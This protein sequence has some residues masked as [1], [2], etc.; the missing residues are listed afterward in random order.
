MEGQHRRPSQQQ[1]QQ[2]Y[3][4]TTDGV[5]A[6]AR[7]TS[8]YVSALRTGGGSTVGSA[9]G[10]MVSANSGSAMAP[11]SSTSL[12]RNP[13]TGS[14]TAGSG[15]KGRPAPIMTSHSAMAAGGSGGPLSPRTPTSPAPALSPYFAS[16][17]YPGSLVRTGSNGSSLVGGKRTATAA[18]AAAIPAAPAPQRSTST[19]GSLPRPLAASASAAVTAAVPTSGPRMAYP[20]PPTSPMA[21]SPT[22]PAPVYDV[23]ALS[24]G[25]GVGGSTLGR[26]PYMPDRG[27]AWAAPNN[28]KSAPL[29]P[30]FSP[31]PFSPTGGS[32]GEKFGPLAPY[33]QEQ[34]QQQYQEQQ[35]QQ[36]QQQ[37]QQQGA[38][39]WAPQQQAHEGPSY[40]TH[41]GAGGGQPDVEAKPQAWTPGRVGGTNGPQ[42]DGPSFAAATLKKMPSTGAQG[43]VVDRDFELAVQEIVPNFDHPDT[44]SFTF[45]VM[46]LGTFFCILIAGVTQVFYYYWNYFVPSPFIA[47]I[48]SFPLGKFLERSLPS[49]R[50]YIPFIGTVDTNP[51]PFSVKELT[52][53]G[54]FASTATSGVY[55]LSNLVVTEH[56]YKKPIG[57]GWSIAFLLSSSTLGFGLAGIL[58]SLLVRPANMIWPTVI[59]IVSLYS[60]F[61]GFGVDADDS[62]HGSVSSAKEQGRVAPKRWSR[63]FVFVL[64]MGGMMV[65]QLILA[66]APQLSNFGLLCIAQRMFSTQ[67][68][69]VQML[70]NFNQGVGIGSITFD[71]T[72]IGSYNMQVPWWTTAS[73][74]FGTVLFVWILVPLAWSRNWFYDESQAKLPLNSIG[75]MYESGK[76]F[77]ANLDVKSVIPNPPLRI[78]PYFAI[79]YFTSFAQFPAAVV[80]TAVWYGGDIWRRVRGVNKNKMDLDIHCLLIDQYP[81][82]PSSIYGALFVGSAVM[83]FLVTQFAGMTDYEGSGSTISIETFAVPLSVALGVVAMLPVAVV[84]ATAGVNIGLNIVSEVVWGYVN[85][86]NPLTLMLFKSISVLLASQCTM[87]LQDLK[88]GHYM[89]VPPRH[90]FSAQLLAQAITVFVGYGVNLYWFSSERNIGLLVQDEKYVEEKSHWDDVNDRTFFSASLIY[91]AIGPGKFFSPSTP[92]GSLL[93]LGACIGAITPLVFKVADMLIGPPIPWQLIQAPV[94]FNITSPGSGQSYISG[95]IVALVSQVW[96]LRKRFSTWKRY[97]YV[98]SAAFDAACGIVGAFVALYG[99]SNELPA[100]ALNPKSDTFSGPNKDFCF[101]TSKQ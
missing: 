64:F 35:G 24:S 82:V 8:V 73:T 10:S 29:S 62:D 55:G 90:M 3:L 27:A 68:E 76:F 93:W 40:G 56:I 53:I 49:W 15:S 5:A 99:I 57:I 36:F 88:L 2:Q 74:F 96:L 12:A 67:T 20:G 100:W 78:S 21:P 33:Q 1:Q 16:E 59:P 101:Y 17:Y 26:S 79:S 32:A 30:T 63:S 84:N 91:G 89:K 94:I 28:W 18:M 31:P 42:Q 87:L 22:S 7:S 41:P 95:L 23:G 4:S 47:I 58:R 52:L 97:N 83:L 11:S 46:L 37:Q 44:P 80:H 72:L 43:F 86:G 81:E 65:W 50:F 66:F 61:F 45:R 71:W 48:L 75:L 98:V 60:A 34:P 9:L 69:D 92:Y 14:R 38:I 25:S 19:A 6:P 51:G 54:V 13:S 39:S 77:E 85:P 70:G